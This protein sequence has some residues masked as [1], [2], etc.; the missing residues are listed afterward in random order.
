LSENFFS[1]SSAIQPERVKFYAVIVLYRRELQQSQTWR[2]LVPLVEK[3]AGSPVFSLLICENEP[4]EAADVELPKWAE[5]LSRADNGGLA[6]AYNAGLQRAI[7]TGAQWLLT[8]DQDTHLPTDFLEKM[9]SNV[10]ALSKRQEIA[11]I[12]PQLISVTGEVYS[13]FFAKLGR[14]RAVSRGF[15]GI[16]RG[17]LRAFN[18]A[19]LLRVSW[20]EKIGGYPSLFWLDF[21]DHATFRS[22]REAGG[23]IWI[24]GQLQLE[25]HLSLKEERHSMNEPRIAK[26]LQ[27][28]SGVVDL[29]G[30]FLD[31]W[32]YTAR[33]PL[34]LGNQWRRGD[35]Q[36]FLKQTKLLLLQRLTTRRRQR[37]AAWMESERPR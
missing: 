29:Y 13:P 26:F 32:L 6:W 2:T 11:A 16:G 35:N 18:S 17:D 20:L 4:P 3:L 19:A 24:D 23:E 15:T 9:T 36:F 28:E 37:L 34:R 12:V 7:A 5:R 25:H 8:L 10:S 21:L 33:L 27:A 31:R 1:V 22:L 30:S 14:E